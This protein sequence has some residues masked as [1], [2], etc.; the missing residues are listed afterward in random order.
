MAQIISQDSFLPDI[1]RGEWR[2]GIFACCNLGCFHPSLC[3]GAWLTP[4]A[5]GQVLARM[6]LDCCARPGVQDAF[7]AHS[8]LFFLTAGLYVIVFDFTVILLL[9]DHDDGDETP[10]WVRFMI[11]FMIVLGSCFLFLVVSNTMKARSFIRKKYDIPEGKCGG[12]EDACCA[13][14]CNPCSICQMSRHS[15]DYRSN[16]AACCTRNGL[17]DDVKN[18][19]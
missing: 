16:L 1:P 3:L 17:M 13:I 8:V 11:I 6:K 15:A 2:D 10:K 19:V 7:S 12:C 18:P 14:F 4:C 5:L 9:Y